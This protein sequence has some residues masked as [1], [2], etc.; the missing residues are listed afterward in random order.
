M[1]FHYNHKTEFHS[2]E[3]LFKCDECEKS[4]KDENKRDKHLK[5]HQKYECDECDKVFKY[6]ENLDKHMEAVHDGFILFCHYYNN[7]KECPFGEE[8]IFDHE[9][10]GECRYGKAC[11]REMCMFTHD[12]KN[13]DETSDNYDDDNDAEVEKI[14]PVL[15]KVR[16]AVK[17]CDDLI[18]KC[19]LNCKDCEFEAKDKNG[20]TMHAKAKHTTKAN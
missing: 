5:I 14:K 17:K 13:N 4:F 2:N 18:E 10:S 16:M 1:N 15:E 6:E 19:S 12:D 7:N 3:E 11:E 20:L 9:E 8:C